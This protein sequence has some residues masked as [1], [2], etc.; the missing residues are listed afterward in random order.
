LKNPR[1]DHKSEVVFAI[2]VPNIIINYLGYVT[3]DSFSKIRKI[4]ETETIQ[5]FMEKID[6]P[7]ETLSILRNLL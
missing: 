6:F 3:I 1:K 5:E 7:V 4:S 2:L